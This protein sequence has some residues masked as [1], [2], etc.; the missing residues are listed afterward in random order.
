M[1]H[2]FP[3]GTAGLYDF[4]PPGA[5]L[6]SNI[7]AAW[8]QHFIVEDDMLELDA[9]ALT[10]APL[11][12]ASGHLENFAARWVVKDNGTNEVLS[13]NELIESVLQTRLKGSS[14]VRSE[15]KPN[16][17]FLPPASQINII[18]DTTRNKY[19]TI[20][21]VVHNVAGSELRNIIMDHNIVNPKT[22][23]TVTDPIQFNLMF[24]VAIGEAAQSG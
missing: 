7:V 15:A 12:A 11:F 13:A 6:Q 18:D 17:T 10:P 2:L 5:A 3:S 1:S 23:N 22:G 20:L 9:P 19:T 8:R 21:E 24:D 14:S 4:G 16:N